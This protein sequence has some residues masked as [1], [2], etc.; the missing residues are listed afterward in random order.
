MNTNHLI[1]LSLLLS[2]TS[3]ACATDPEQPKSSASEAVIQHHLQA[4][5]A[6]D[7]DEVLADYTEDSRWFIGDQAFRGLDQIRTGHEMIFQL[8]PAG[9]TDLSIDE[10]RADGDLVYITYH[11]E[12]P[13]V[14]VPFGSDTFIVVDG[15]IVTETVGMLAQPKS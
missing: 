13:V 6:N 9:A 2:L 12:S 7:M 1:A 15:K 3:A 14:T 8:A 10:F 5:L 4:L 11:G